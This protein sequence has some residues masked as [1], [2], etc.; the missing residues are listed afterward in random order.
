M[1]FKIIVSADRMCLW[2][3]VCKMIFRKSKA[4]EVE[5]LFSEGY[6]VWSKNRSFEKYSDDNSKEDAY[7]TRFVLEDNEEIVSSLIW[8]DMKS[9]NGKKVYGIGSV[10]TPAIYKHKGYATEL[11]KNCLQQI[12]TDESIVFLYSEV[13]PAFYERFQFRVLPANLQKD[14]DSICMVLCDD[15]MWKELLNGSIEPIPDHF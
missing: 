6:K 15:E 2:N 3:G 11:L 10:L 5:K 12:S 7:G 4:E 14:A 1:R 9:I 8:L 13:N